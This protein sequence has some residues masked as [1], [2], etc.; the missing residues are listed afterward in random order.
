MPER[1]TI[2]IVG[3]GASAVC[4]LDALSQR[5]VVP[6]GVVIFEPSP[7]VWRGRA[8]QPDSTTLRVN[9]PP[10]D[11][12]VRFGDVHHFERWA[13]ARRLVLND[14]TDYADPWSGVPFVPR[15]MFGD[16]LE[17]SARAA[18]SRLVAHGCRVSLERETVTAVD[19][20]AGGLVLRTGSGGRHRADYAVLCVGGGRPADQYQLLGSP[21]FV[22]DPYPVFTRMAEIRPDDDVAVIGSGLTAVDIVLSLH[23]RGHRGRI[24]LLSRRGVLPAVRQR[25]VGYE[26]QHFTPQYF[27]AKAAL[28]ET[29]TFDDV[30][31]VMQEELAAAD[32]DLDDVFL[33]I[34]AV[35][36][37]EPVE[38]LRRQLAA[39]DEEGLGL[40]ILQR[41]VPD[42][43]PDVW[44]LLPEAE[45]TALV[46]NHYRTIM[47]LCCPMPPA[48]AA[49]LLAL[50]ADGQVE[51]LRG[52][53]HLSAAPGG[54]F[55]IRA[56]ERSRHAAVVV[57]A[58]NAPAHRIPQIAEPM[59]NSLVEGG[60]AR[61]HPRGGLHVER[62]TSRLTVEGRT[63]PRLHALG[64][65]AAGSLFFTFGV[66]SLVDRAYDIADAIVGDAQARA[67]RL[68]GAMQAA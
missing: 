39:V 32:V 19:Y 4:L 24:S 52:L 21:G 17:Q 58:V 36:G 55:R 47:S 53:E 7:H 35:E 60:M 64:D 51:I 56:G 26:L 6:G 45:K 49:T 16:Y 63:D 54:G 34:M 46:R 15:A 14:H 44:P 18:L 61:L 67:G 9:A 41:A 20:A 42:T 57:N 25:P 66:P 28:G 68:G 62:A 65:L 50:I 11:M 29:L 3:A 43:G 1:M 22:P 40:R 23:M 59:V 33:E 12:S 31:Q 48:S 5:D 27:R 2:A 37:E 30:S 10:D 38:R 13:E 8:Y